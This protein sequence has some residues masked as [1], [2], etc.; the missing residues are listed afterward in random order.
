MRMAG[1]PNHSSQ[2]LFLPR[3]LDKAADFL[4]DEIGDGAIDVK[5]GQPADGALTG[6]WR[7]RDAGDASERCRLPQ[8]GDATHMVNVGLQNIND[9]HLDQLAATVRSDQ[10][11]PRSDGC[12]GTPGNAGHGRNIFRRARLFYEQQVQRLYFLDDDGSDTGTGFGMEIHRDIDI[13]P[14]VFAEILHG[15]HRTLDFPVRFNVFVFSWDAA[16]VQTRV[17]GEGGWAFPY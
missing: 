7:H 11:F 3:G 12:S 8:A 17:R 15:F 6:M 5:C 4:N 2:I 10:P 9:T 14:K 1:K 13:G 16:L